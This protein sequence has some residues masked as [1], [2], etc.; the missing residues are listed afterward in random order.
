MTSE[1]CVVESAQV[2][3][4]VDIL[5]H[6]FNSFKCLSSE[7]NLSNLLSIDILH[8][9][10]NHLVMSMYIIKYLSEHPTRCIVYH[11]THKG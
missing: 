6:L 4:K 2:S 5:Y 3:Y 11:V 9:S 1:H 7:I 8:N 10:Q